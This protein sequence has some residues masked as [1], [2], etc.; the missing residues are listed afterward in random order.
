MRGSDFKRFVDLPWLS[1]SFGLSFGRE[2]DQ[3]P[4]PHFQ[5]RRRYRQRLAEDIGE[6]QGGAPHVG[7][8]RHGCFDASR[9][10]FRQPAFQ[11]GREI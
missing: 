10:R 5:A 9:R 4:R 11:P 7:I 8:A 3:G 2:A 6:F 1:L